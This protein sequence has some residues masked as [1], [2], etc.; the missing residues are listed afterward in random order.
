MINGLRNQ[1]RRFAGGSSAHRGVGGEQI[2]PVR[3]IGAAEKTE[4]I[5]IAVIAH[6]ALES[7]MFVYTSKDR[8]ENTRLL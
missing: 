3:L 8:E 4:T 5:F 6:N 7:Q 1:D 2:F